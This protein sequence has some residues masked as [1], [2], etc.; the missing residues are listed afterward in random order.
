MQRIRNN[1]SGGSSNTLTRSIVITE[2]GETVLVSTI[3]LLGIDHGFGGT[4]LF[5]ET[6]VFTM[7]DN[8]EDVIDWCERD[9]MRYTTAEQAMEG[10]ADMV[11]K[12]FNYTKEP[13]AL[14]PEG[15]TVALLPAG[16]E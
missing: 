15:T 6:M 2:G 5:Y 10:H 11:T 16:S 4:P 8:G 7:D 12:W 1:E 13:V 14:L 9:C 3:S